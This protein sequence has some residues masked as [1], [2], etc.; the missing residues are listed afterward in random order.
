MPASRRFRV[1]SLWLNRLILWLSLL[2]MLL[3]VHL[4]IQKA[5]GFDQGCLGVSTHSTLQGSGCRE[6]SDLPASHLLGISNAAWGYAFYFMLALI[7]LA[8]IVVS[9]RWA[10][11]L[12]S[13]SE[14]GVAAALAY[15]GY[16]VFEM[17]FVAQTW[18]VLCTISAA[19]VA[20]LFAIHV[21]LRF[22]GEFR[23]IDAAER[24]NELAIA[25][26]GLFVTSGVLVG[27]LLFINRLGTRPFDQGNDGKE[28][29][30]IIGETLPIYIDRAKLVEMRACHFDRTAPPLDISRFVDGQ[31]P[32]LGDPRGVPITVFYDPD[33]EHCKAH[34]EVLSRLV[35]KLQGQA[36][37]YVVPD[38]IWPRSKIAVE[39][40]I[41]ARHS[42]KYFELWRRLFDHQGQGPW[43]VDRVREVFTQVGLDST[44]LEKRLQSVREEMMARQNQIDAIDISS[45]PAVFIGDTKVWAMNQTADCIAKLFDQKTQR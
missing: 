14:L 15:S 29:E 43:T 6:V 19:L 3:A 37:F 36:R 39:A 42:D 9:A 32:F 4:W 28:L 23:L 34:Y 2:G 20:I 35:E 24:G 1:S 11:R 38:M 45:V 8:K 21:A 33:C 30:R 22:G 25:V 7:S 10:R 12:Q 17:G 27:V 40:L 26:V 5:R 41:L 16:L 18:C 44:D 31:T 13:A